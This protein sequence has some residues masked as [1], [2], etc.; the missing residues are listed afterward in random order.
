MK[1]NRFDSYDKLSKATAEEILHCISCK[2]ESVLCLATGE[3]PLLTYQ[4]LVEQAT[5]NKID[6]SKAHFVGLDEWVGIP[7]ENSG[8]CHF[9]LTEKLLR[10][11]KTGAAHIHLFDGMS[12]EIDSECTKMDK[13]I[14]DLGGIDFMIVGIGMNGHIGFNEPGTSLA[15]KSHVIELDNVTQQ[16]GQKYFRS[17]TKLQKG[18]TLGFQNILQAKK[19]ILMANGA[20]KA[21]IIK[22]SL[23]EGITEKCPASILRKHA[24]S[25]VYLDSMA[26]SKLSLW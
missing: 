17:T 11:L 25:Y 23:E 8:T 1:L 10:P 16:V 5:K 22:T 2:P 4:I 14:N 7:P 12:A 13:V 15:L 19:V 3:T 9:F 21:D 18:I 24:N 20:K 26:S 6:F